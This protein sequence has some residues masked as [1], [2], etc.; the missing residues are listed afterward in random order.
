MNMPESLNEKE[1]AYLH[2]TDF[3]LTKRKLIEQLQRVLSLS[4]QQIKQAIEDSKASL[5]ANCLQRAGK[6]SRGE[7]YR[8][9]PYLILDYP[10]LLAKND[11]FSFRS[12]FWWGHFF[13]CTLHLQG[14]SL[15]L[16]R[17][18]LQENMLG[19][20]TALPADTW[21][22]VNST[23][24]EY[25]YEPSNYKLLKEVLPGELRLLLDREFVKLSR[26]MPLQQYEQLS[27]FSSECLHL[28]LSCLR[29][30]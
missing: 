23:P 26:K 24:W 9:L 22:C 7:N 12:M 1:L 20:T 4:Q 27:A 14:Q 5:P 8:G 29:P 28:F 21:I 3:L 2:N 16:Y 13:S 6:I 19:K 30:S 17:S 11:V 25:H 15:Q 18:Q 10:R